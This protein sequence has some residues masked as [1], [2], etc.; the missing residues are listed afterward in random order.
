MFALQPNFRLLWTPQT[1]YSVWLGVSRASENSSRFDADIRVN[2][3]AF[4]ASNGVTT[5]L[6]SFGTHSLP[7]ENV[8]AYELGQR[9][10]VR[11]WM[12]FD[13]STFFNHYTNRHTHEPGAPFLEDDPAPRHLVEPQTT[14]SNITGETHGIEASATLKSEAFWKLS[15]SYDLF[16]I[17]LHALPASKDFSTARES[18]GSTPRH[19][20]KVRLALQ[21]DEVEGMAKLFLDSHQRQR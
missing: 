1:R 8:V 16:E 9:A 6:S 11:K 21:L 5:L 17:H 20:F 2:Q 18:E 15:A 14:V 7:P 19:S 4:I 13:V 3:D 10:Q 12:L